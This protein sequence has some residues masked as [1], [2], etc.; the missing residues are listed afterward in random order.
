MGAIHYTSLDAH[1]RAGLQAIGLLS[2]IIIRQPFPLRDAPIGRAGLTRHATAVLADDARWHDIFSPRASSRATPLPR[3]P[4]RA[5][6]AYTTGSRHLI[7]TLFI[8]KEPLK[9]AACHRR[10]AAHTL[11]ASAKYADLVANMLSHGADVITYRRRT[12]PWLNGHIFARLAAM[13]KTERHSA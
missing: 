9:T 3:L 2:L 10:Y 1:E 6:R 5:R 8:K 7:E 13:L 4:Q 12:M 11:E